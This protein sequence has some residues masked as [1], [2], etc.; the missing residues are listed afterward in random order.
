M[1][2]H[3]YLRSL[4]RKAQ[5]LSGMETRNVFQL[6]PG[7]FQN[8]RRR[9]TLFLL[10]NGKSC[11]VAEMPQLIAGNVSTELKLH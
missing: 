8:W 6:W 9:A 2:D 7:G 11:A 3:N 1:A 5:G 4:I 10:F